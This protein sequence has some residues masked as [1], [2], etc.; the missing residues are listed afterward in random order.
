M[1]KLMGRFMTKRAAERFAEQKNKRA[2]KY[3]YRAAKE[4]FYGKPGYNGVQS[5]W[6]TVISRKKGL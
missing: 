4:G 2:R 3:V 5:G 1:S 6:T